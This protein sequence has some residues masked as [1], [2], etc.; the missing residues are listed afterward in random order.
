M[1]QSELILLYS[2]PAYATFVSGVV[3]E[4][5]IISLCSQYFF[6]SFF[7]DK[8]DEYDFVPENINKKDCKELW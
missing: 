2:Y 1:L 6:P 3:I 5:F 4:I 8:K 7:N